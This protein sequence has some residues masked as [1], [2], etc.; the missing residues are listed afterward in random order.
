[1]K[2]NQA[3][4]CIAGSVLLLI[5]YVYANM[6]GLGL[7]PDSYMYLKQAEFFDQNF[8]FI[9][10]EVHPLFPFQTFLIVVLSFFPDAASGLKYM[11]IIQAFL[12]VGN[13]ILLTVLAGRIFVKPVYVFLFAG[14]IVFSTPLLMVHSFLWTEP[15]FIFTVS[16]LLWLI[17]KHM[18][19]PS[20]RNYVI[21]F[22]LLV[23]LCLQRKAGLLFIAGTALGLILFLSSFSFR[24][25]LIL[26]LSGLTLV[27]LLYAFDVVGELPVIGNFWNHVRDY[28]DFLS[29]WLLPL[30]VPFLIRIVFLVGALFFITVTLFTQNKNSTS[31]F[32]KVLF[33]IFA[34]YC[35]VRLFYFRPDRSEMDRYLAPIFP[36][37]FLLLFSSIEYRLEKCSMKVRTVVLALLFLWLTYPAIR[38][39]KN[40]FLWHDRYPVNV[41]KTL[42]QQSILIF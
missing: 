13:F 32:L 33:S 26:V 5:L 27:T 42:N 1:M 19:Q 15:F 34:T 6:N 28:A 36:I 35:F 37:F 24:I 8:S 23:L 3:I 22:F 29:A 38:T 17:F 25:K 2:P 7:T 40:T 12:L 11:S 4:P 30:S 21:L 31:L 20:Y 39:I 16:V 9:A 18:Q 14:V 10:N 41:S